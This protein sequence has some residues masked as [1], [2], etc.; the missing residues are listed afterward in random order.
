MINKNPLVFGAV[1]SLILVGN[2]YSLTI[3]SKSA[4]GRRSIVK[5]SLHH[6]PPLEWSLL[7]AL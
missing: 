1:L 3:T 4:D 7:L 2:A 6:P 5:P